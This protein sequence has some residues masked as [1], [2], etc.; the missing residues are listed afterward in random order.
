MISPGALMA[1]LHPEV[2]ARVARWH[3]LVPTW[4]R[5]VARRE[6]K[7]RLMA[8]TVKNWP[9]IRQARERWR[10]ELMERRLPWQ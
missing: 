5:D 6:I 1:M 7:R 9:Q 3:P 10:N 8:H 4:L 2:L